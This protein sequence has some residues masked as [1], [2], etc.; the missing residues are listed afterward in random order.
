M[1]Q[2]PHHEVSQHE[3]ACAHP[4]KS[5]EEVMMALEAIDARRLEEQ[6]V[7][8]DIFSLLSFEK[9]TFNGKVQ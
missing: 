1:W 5:G 3:D 6:K 2:G 9:I 4:R 8:K 7:Y